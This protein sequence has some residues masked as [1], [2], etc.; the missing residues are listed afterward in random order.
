[1]EW[2]GL[3]IGKRLEEG[4]RYFQPLLEE[5]KGKDRFKCYDTVFYNVRVI[6]PGELNAWAKYYEVA[7]LQS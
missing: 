7:P 1:M 6:L 3:P 5:F 4:G 2:L